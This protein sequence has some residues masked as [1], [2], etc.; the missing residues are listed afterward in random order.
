MTQDLRLTD[1]YLDEVILRKVRRVEEAARRGVD[2]T[3]DVEPEEDGD[4]SL[5]VGKSANIGRSSKLKKEKDRTHRGMED[6]DE[7]ED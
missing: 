1:L 3:S 4:S 5:V 2:D 6:I 7:D